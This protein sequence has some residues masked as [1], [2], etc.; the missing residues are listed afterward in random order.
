[1]DQ[2][3]GDREER[4]RRRAYEIWEENGRA[5]GREG[6]HW[7]QARQEIEGAEE[8][9]T[10]QPPIEMPTNPVDETDND[11]VESAQPSRASE[12]PS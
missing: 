9:V 3:D 10:A 12:I 8:G 1:M 5:E 7:Q 2:S 4:I 6:E 11:R